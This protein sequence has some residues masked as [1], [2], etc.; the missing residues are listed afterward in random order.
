LT[1]LQ[2]RFS[3]FVDQLHRSQTEKHEVIHDPDVE[4]ERPLNICLPEESHQ[5]ALLRLQEEVKDLNQLQLLLDNIVIVHE[6]L[7]SDLKETL[8]T[9]TPQI[10]AALFHFAKSASGPYISFSVL[11]STLSIDV[12]ERWLIDSPDLLRTTILDSYDPESIM[13]PPPTP[14]ASSID[15][16]W[17]W[18][19][20]RP[21]Y[22]LRD[23]TKVVQSLKIV[24][25]S[26]NLQKLRLLLEGEEGRRVAMVYGSAYVAREDRLIDVAKIKLE[27]VYNAISVR[28]L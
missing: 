11:R 13:S 1:K 14:S 9:S 3:F 17:S 21:L 10:G 4:I 6:T 16:L 27:T 5:T 7:I 23:Y 25:G 24:E 8:T 26:G 12:L 18:N 20:S 2:S 15:E 19:L 28:R 22:R